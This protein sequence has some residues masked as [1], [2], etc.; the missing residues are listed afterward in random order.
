MSKEDKKF[1]LKLYFKNLDDESN[2]GIKNF[3]LEQFYEE[4][5]EI[6]EVIFEEDLGFTKE[7]I[8][9]DFDLICELCKNQ[10]N[11]IDYAEEPNNRYINKIEYCYYEKCKYAEYD[12]DGNAEFSEKLKDG[13]ESKK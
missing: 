5:K 2:E 1:N 4:C 6:S 9:R 7:E 12:K 10:G 8:E 3:T 13:M 11:S